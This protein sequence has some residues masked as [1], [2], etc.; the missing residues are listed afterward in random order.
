M[1]K[2]DTNSGSGSDSDSELEQGMT[3]YELEQDIREDPVA[4]GF[5][6][7]FSLTNKEIF[8]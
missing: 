7:Y 5:L 2:S 3:D 4:Q 6:N 8:C 1:E